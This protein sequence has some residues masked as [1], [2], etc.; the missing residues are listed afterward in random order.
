MISDKV[1][2]YQAMITGLVNEVDPQKPKIDEA[3]LDD[4][5]KR[6]LKI[7]EKMGLIKVTSNK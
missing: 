1:E 5:V 6:I 2:D 7:K 4:A 3:R